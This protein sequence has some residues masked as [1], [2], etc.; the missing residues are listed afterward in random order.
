M[1]TSGREPAVTAPKVRWDQAAGLFFV[2]FDG[3]RL[4]IFGFEDL[5]AIEAF[6]IVHAVAAGDDYRF[7]MLAGGLHT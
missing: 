2:R 6:H 3:N 7:L 1:A 5:F 4:Q